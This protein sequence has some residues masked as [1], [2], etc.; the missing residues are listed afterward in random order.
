MS[1]ANGWF[2]TSL[3]CTISFSAQAQSAVQVTFGSKGV[4]RV[5]YNGNTLEDTNR[6][7]DDVFHI[8]HMKLTD[9]SGKL[10]SGPQYDW[11]EVNNAKSWNPVTHA[12]TYSFRW[13]SINV[14]FVPDGNSLDM[15]VTAQNF[16]GSGVIFHGAV[17]YPLALHFP[18]LPAGFGDSSYE[19][20]AFNTTGPSVTLADYG[21]GQVATVLADASKPLYTGFEPAGMPYAYYP[22]VSG[23]G[24]DNMATFFPRNDRPVAPG[25]TDSFTVALRFAPSGIDLGTLAAD[26]YRA[27]AQKWPSQV[28]WPDRRIIGTAYLASSGDGPNHLAAGF[29]NNPRRYSNTGNPSDFD[30]RSGDGLNKFQHRILQQ[31]IDNVTNLQRMNAQGIVTWDIEGQQFPHNT[32]YVCSPD[33]IAQVAPEMESVVG[34]P[35]SP[36]NGMKLDDAY[37]KIMR[38]AGFRVGVCVRPQHFSF[39][40]NGTA[41]QSFLPAS[42]IAAELT[43][44]MRYAHDRWG[45]TLFY[46]DS[47]VDANG[48]V[49]DPGI[50]QQVS[51]SMPDSLLIPEESSPKYYAYTAPFQTFIFHNDLGTPSEIYNYYP[52]AFSVNLVNDVDAGRLAQYRSQLT[53]SVRH[54][55]ILMLH[56]DY[57]QANNSTAVEIYQSAGAGNVPPV[58]LPSAPVPVEPAP[59]PVPPAPVAPEPVSGPVAPVLPPAPSPAPSGPVV[60]ANVVNGSVLSGSLTLNA[61]IEGTLDSAGSYLMVDGVEVGTY[62]NTNGPYAYPVDTTQFN[63]GDHVLQVWAHNINNETLT[64]APVNVTFRNA[65]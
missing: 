1:L 9:L 2:L 53:E 62:R 3:L 11:G 43:A 63:D 10:L 49:L 25:E 45:A 44:K 7:R 27:W 5:D 59:I 60:I 14:Q 54:G 12:W 39:Y 37:F 40:G 64:S 22:V 32:S 48:G 23:T 16:S 35:S 20:F 65:R 4:E 46:I 50:F 38:D 6:F 8:G 34:D 19:H 33:Q 21:D 41:E 47:T 52:R 36:Y 29:L 56:A 28:Q 58:T 51:A 31:A 55:D 24:L 17:I 13:G 42:Q 30:I 26:A 15:N 57:W 61:S 18:R